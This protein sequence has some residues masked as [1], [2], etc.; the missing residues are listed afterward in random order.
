MRLS[1]IIIIEAGEVDLTDIDPSIAQKLA[2]YPSHIKQWGVG[3]LR[4][5]EDA[6]SVIDAIKYY[7]AK[8]K[9]NRFTEILSKITPTPRNI[10]SLSLDQIKSA[11]SEFDSLYAGPSK[12]ELN[13]LRRAKYATTLVDE[14]GFKIIKFQKLDDTDNGAKILSN[15]AR[16]TKWCV[17]DVTIGDDYLSKDPIYLIYKS[18]DFVTDPDTDPPINDYGEQLRQH[19]DKMLLHVQSNQL[20]NPIDRPMYLGEDDI[21]D[22]KPYVKGIS[23]FIDEQIIGGNGWQS[24]LKFGYDRIRYRTSKGNW[25]E[26]VDKNVIGFLEAAI[27]D[28]QAAAKVAEIAKTKSDTVKGWPEAE[29]II[30]RD[31][32]AAVLYA[33]R[34][35]EERWKDAESII[36]SDGAAAFSY[37]ERWDTIRQYSPKA[38]RQRT[39]LEE[40]KHGWPE[41]EPA[42]SKVTWAALSY[43]AKYKRQ[44]WPEV[45]Q[46]LFNSL[47]DS[48]EPG[49][50]YTLLTYA[51]DYA[52]HIYPNGWPQLEEYLKHSPK[53]ALYCHRVLK[54]RWPEAEPY[55]MQD[56]YQAAYYAVEVM[57]E[58]WPEAEKIIATDEDAQNLYDRLTP[59]REKIYSLGD[60]WYDALDRASYRIGRIY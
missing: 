37:L 28:P 30:K 25:K 14:P 41:A 8:I 19:S 43:A 54:R 33:T 18:V 17:T 23:L 15:Y 48:D 52:G 58:R 11:Q 1:Q 50:N 4:K 6:N 10:L 13:R 55:I 26:D 3:E 38:S 27:E 24:K 60:D 31:P 45:E 49:D 29:P 7:L 42:I 22:I 47:K 32:D 20:M 2:V 34:V 51:I 35:L 36:A 16:G 57:K 12:A 9:D 39:D 56:P 21:D 5:G 46:A 40:F 59:Q 44:P 53:A